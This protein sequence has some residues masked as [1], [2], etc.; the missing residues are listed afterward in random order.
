MGGRSFDRGSD[1]GEP[2]KRAGGLFWWWSFSPAP[3]IRGRADCKPSLQTGEGW[4]I[5]SISAG[6]LPISHAKQTIIYDHDQFQQ[7]ICY[8]SLQ[9]QI[10][11]LPALLAALEHPL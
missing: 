11:L 10:Q 4:G 8:S 7:Q 6:D 2:L 9:F 3:N 1:C 5:Y